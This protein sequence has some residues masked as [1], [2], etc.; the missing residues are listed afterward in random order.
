M[1]KI[2][3]LTNILQYSYEPVPMKVLAEKLSC[4]PRTIRTLITK[5]IRSGDKVISVIERKDFGY[6]LVCNASEKLIFRERQIL[7]KRIR[8]SLRKL[9]AL[10][11]SGTI[12]QLATLIEQEE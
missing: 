2:Q 3:H 11:K 7:I 10:N 6:I 8:T 1:T 12:I 5:M 9:K 4:T